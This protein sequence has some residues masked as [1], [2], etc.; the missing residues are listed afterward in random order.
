M[1]LTP[2]SCEGFDEFLRL[3]VYVGDY[4]VDSY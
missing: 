3:I 2:M 4:G 1:C